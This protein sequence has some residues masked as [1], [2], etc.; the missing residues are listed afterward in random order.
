[1]GTTTEP[2]TTARWGAIAG[3]ACLAISAVGQL[4]QYLVT[5]LVSQGTEPA[6]LVAQ[7]AAHPSAM[8]LASWLDLAI[9]F[10]VPAVLVVGRLAGAARS[11]LA[12]VATGITFVT[13]L[14]GS[15]YLLATDVLVQPPGTAAGVAAYLADPVVSTVTLVFLAGHVVG[16]LLLAV[17]LGRSR[18]VPVWAA[19]AL[20]VFPLAEIGGQAIGI[21]PVSV[22]AYL[23]L[24]VAFGACAAAVLRRAPA[25]AAEDRARVAS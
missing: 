14:L 16:F 12:A 15:G 7:A 21:R 2:A 5:P 10:L 23:L 19:V 20:G 3:V 9:L 24:V 6:D 18:A 8:R 11:P 13:T 4:V 1:M 25:G 22:V 17:A